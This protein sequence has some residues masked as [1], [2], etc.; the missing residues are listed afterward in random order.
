[1]D[2]RTVIV[3]KQKIQQ[4]RDPLVELS[5]FGILNDDNIKEI[6]TL[7]NNN[8]NITSVALR[9]NSISD[10]ATQY[11]AENLI[12]VI[13]LDL[14]LNNCADEGAIAL[15]A[16]EKFR[17][18]NLQSNR[19]IKNKDN[20]VY[21]AVLNNTTCTKLLLTRS[22]KGELLDSIV[23][24]CEKNLKK[25]KANSNVSKPFKLDT[26]EKSVLTPLEESKASPHGLLSAPSTTEISTNNPSRL[27]SQ[28]KVQLTSSSTPS[29]RNGGKCCT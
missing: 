21:E 6:V 29:H 9:R 2:T 4:C 27:F 16:C 25:F 3:Y 20:K 12:R 18:I 24:H 5:D 17:W 15:L 11:L 7:I 19:S 8:P 14:D 13:M 23:D 1:M 22:I 28:S 26:S 10:K